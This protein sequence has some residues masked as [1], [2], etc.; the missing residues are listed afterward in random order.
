MLEIVSMHS[1][2]LLSQIG[3]T[4]K[5]KKDPTVTQAYDPYDLKNLGASAQFLLDSLSD[6]LRHAIERKVEESCSGPEIWMAIVDEVQSD[7]TRRHQRIKE[8][9]RK[10]RLSSYGNE[11]VK[12][13]MQDAIEMFRELDNA[14]VLEDDLLLTLLEAF[15]KASTETFR[16]TFITQRAD[17]ESFIRAVKGKSTQARQLVTGIKIFTYR[18][19]LNDALSLYMSLLESGDWRPA[20]S[21]SDKGGAPS[22]FARAEAHVLVPNSSKSS[23]TRTMICYNCG[24]TGHMSRDCMKPRKDSTSTQTS[25]RGG[26]RSQG[27]GRGGC[28]G[29]TTDWPSW[30]KDSPKPGEPETRTH[31]GRKFY[32]CGICNHWRTTHSTYGIFSQSVPKH[33]NTLTAGK[34]PTSLET[35]KRF[36][37]H[38]AEGMFSD[39]FDF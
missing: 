6:D 17:L 29:R 20:I 21:I 1:R 5:E 16:V 26:R 30:Q 11:N 27:R 7:T 13:F 34:T 32:W 8:D 15:T 31:D 36:E 33:T 22:A 18:S 35:P 38:I 39:D 24:E 12:L 14:N 37:G 19:L 2:F 3:D 4:V 23:N 28:G 25:G 9:L 10:L